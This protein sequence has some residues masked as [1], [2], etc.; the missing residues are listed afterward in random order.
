MYGRVSNMDRDAT[1][2]I[3]CVLQESRCHYRSNKSINQSDIVR[4]PFQHRLILI[5]E[6]AS[7]YIH[8]LVFD[9][10]VGKTHLVSSGK[11][12]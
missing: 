4:S 7:D 10:Y 1:Y 12:Q 2:L 8:S 3:S 9:Q 5:P 11:N 6:L